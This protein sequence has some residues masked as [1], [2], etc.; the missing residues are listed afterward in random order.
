MDLLQF[1]DAG[2]RI[3]GICPHFVLPAHPV[4][5]HPLPAAILVLAHMDGIIVWYRHTLLVLVLLVRVERRLYATHRPLRSVE[6]IL[7]A[8]RSFLTFRT[9]LC[10]SDLCRLNGFHWNHSLHPQT[11]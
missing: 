11:P 3:A 5:R 6:R 7:Y 1:L 2:H 9:P 4:A 10:N 8:L